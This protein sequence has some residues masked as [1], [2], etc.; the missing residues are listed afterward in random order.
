[1]YYV[2]VWYLRQYGEK[3]TISYFKVHKCFK[4]DHGSAFDYIQNLL[5]SLKAKAFNDHEDNMSKDFCL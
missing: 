3:L 2:T 1:M 5:S 4:L